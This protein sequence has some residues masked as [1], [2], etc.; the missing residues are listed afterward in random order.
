MRSFDVLV[1]IV[2]PSSNPAACQGL[3]FSYGVHPIDL[4]ADPD[5]WRAF[6]K[7]WRRKHRVAAEHVM[8]VAGP[9]QKN[10]AANHRIELMHLD[11]PA[12]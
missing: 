11:V 12:S 8:L 3:A 2:A 7:T 5:D 10:P 4:A 6:A 1:W 9:S